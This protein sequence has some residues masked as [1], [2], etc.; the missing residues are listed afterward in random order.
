MARFLPL[1][2]IWGQGRI[3]NVQATSCTVRNMDDKLSASSRV[4]SAY[5]DF[6]T[7]AWSTFTNREGDPPAQIETVYKLDFLRFGELETSDVYFY[8]FQV[9]E[10]MVRRCINAQSRFEELIPYCYLLKAFGEGVPVPTILAVER[11]V[12]NMLEARRRSKR[13]KEP[14]DHEVG[15]G[16]GAK[17]AVA[18]KAKTS[19]KGSGAKIEGETKGNVAEQ[20]GEENIL[21]TPIIVVHIR[22]L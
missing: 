1:G 6:P 4:N 8:Q 19:A 20:D 9:V 3:P 21:R 16:K 7:P 22:K 18:P 11:P 2:T 13:V 12:I 15:A 10:E 17:S 5:R 14:D